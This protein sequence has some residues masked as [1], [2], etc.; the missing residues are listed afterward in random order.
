MMIT[1]RLY[2]Q[3]FQCPKCGEKHKE[4]VWATKLFEVKI[5]CAN[6]SCHGKLLQPLFE[7]IPT[8]PMIINGKM[9]SP[10]IHADRRARS[11]KHFETEVLP[12]LGKPDQRM[13]LGRGYK[14]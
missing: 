2:Q 9:T 7:D 12:Y 13:F 14:L 6:K 8:T 5:K 1:D 10:Q 3:E 4:Y 11:K